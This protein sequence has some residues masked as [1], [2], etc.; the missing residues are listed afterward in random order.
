M[1]DQRAGEY[2]I[3][4]IPSYFLS[5]DKDDL[6]YLR[7]NL[8]SNEPVFAKLKVDGSTYRIDIAYRGSYTRKMRKRSYT[9][10]F[11]D[12]KKF[13]DARTVHLNAEYLDPSLMRNKLSFDFFKELKVLA[14]DSQHIRLFRNDEFKGLYLQLESVDDLFLKKR[15]LPEGPIYYAENNDANFSLTRDGKKKKSRLSGYYQ[16]CGTSTDDQ[17]LREFI[18]KI[19]TASKSDFPEIISQS[20]NIDTFLNWLIGAVCTMN[21]DGFTHNYSLYHNKVTGLYEIMPW[22]Y[23]GTWGRKISGGVMEHT[24]VPFEG[25]KENHLIYLLLQVPEFRR[26]Y[27]EKLEETLETKFTVDFMEEKVMKLHQSIR[28]D[29]LLDPYKKHRIDLFDQEPDFIFQFIR[30][31]NDYLKSKLK[32]YDL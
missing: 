29:F 1:I 28:P 6:N 5:I 13:F 8:K 7:E 21:N 24:Y 14:P 18:S 23:D 17:F 19:N 31:R 30:K 20:L 3:Y 22:D 15:N 25:K 4:S 26:M 9:L 16:A 27:K 2:L 11:N 10:Y 12:E 32:S